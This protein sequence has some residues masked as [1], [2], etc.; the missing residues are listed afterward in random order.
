MTVMDSSNLVNYTVTKLSHY[1]KG[2]IYSLTPS[3]EI[4]VY[5]RIAKCV[6]LSLPLQGST[7]IDGWMNK[8]S[9]NGFKIGKCCFCKNF[10][11]L[12]KRSDHIK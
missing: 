7:T 2:S 3:L 1:F 8:C 11:K 9:Y 12:K 5:F 10:K 6:V 4:N